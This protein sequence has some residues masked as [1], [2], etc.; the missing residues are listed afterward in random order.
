MVSEWLQLRNSEVM[1]ALQALVAKSSYLPLLP[2]PSECVQPFSQSLLIATGFL[3]LSSL[4]H[5]VL[6]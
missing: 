2:S 3:F 5:L 6:R 1:E 4:E